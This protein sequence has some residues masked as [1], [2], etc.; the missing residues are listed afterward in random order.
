[1]MDKQLFTIGQVAKLFRVNIRTLRYYDEAGILKPSVT[2]Q[3]TGYR[4]YSTR[5]FERLNTILYLRELDMPLKQILSFFENKDTDTM[6]E[7]LRQQLQVT[8]EKQRQ[9]EMIQRKLQQRIDT[10]EY[11]S[12]CALEEIQVVSLPERNC[13][14]LGRSIRPDEDLEHPI[15]ELEQKNSLGPIIFLGKIGLSIS[16]EALEN[17]DFSLYSGI[18]LI[19]EEGDEPEGQQRLLPG[20]SHICVRFSGTHT[21][22]AYYYE[23]LFSYME[24]EHLS[25]AGDSVEITLIDSGLT[26]DTSKFVTEIQ[27]PVKKL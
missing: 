10:L 15:R 6:M 17:R 8:M 4:Y 3:D 26:G 27:I 7:L 22:S 11:A 12:S 18:F 24:K 1:M 9:L 2:D 21:N 20:G 5:E 16:R 19:F 23:K 13:A 14:M 25:L